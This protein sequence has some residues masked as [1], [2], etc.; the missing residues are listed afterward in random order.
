MIKN[1][2]YLIFKVLHFQA[3]KKEVEVK[4]ASLSKMNCN[5]INFP[6]EKS[7]H[8]NNKKIIQETPEK[9]TILS[10]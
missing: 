6:S 9:I 7:K 2:S 3:N 8:E 4:R 10:R 1:R 5:L